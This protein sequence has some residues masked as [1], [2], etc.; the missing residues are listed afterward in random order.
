MD[1][2]I[3][4]YRPEDLEQMLS[5][6]NEVVAEGLAFP[7]DHAET[8]QGAAEFF[9][10]Q[11]FCGVARENSSGK[12]A[13]LY[14]LHP[15]NVGRCGHIAN[16]SYA[17]A[18]HARGRGIGRLLVGHS[19]EMAKKLGFR[20]MQFNAVTTDNAAAN[21]LYPQLGFKKLGTIP[22]GYRRDNDQYQDIN[23]YYIDLASK[24]GSAP[25][26]GRV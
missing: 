21:R 22:G 14:I 24:D 19:L 8:P 18:S 23:L 11:S 16:A 3:E 13:G 17:V 12:L 15:N 10:S 5:I 26:S 25:G 2:S 6:W 1:I 9:G 4:E 20:I 7:Q